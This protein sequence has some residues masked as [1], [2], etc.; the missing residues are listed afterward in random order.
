MKLR[1]LT[2]ILA[3]MILVLSCVSVAAAEEEVPTLVISTWPANI[4][5]ITANVF[6]PFEE[7]NNCKIVVDTGNNSERLA[8]LKENPDGY[9]V[10]YYMTTHSVCHYIKIG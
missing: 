7:A 10:V 1:K 6:K 4:D 3:A 8:K 9:D 5:T 2:A